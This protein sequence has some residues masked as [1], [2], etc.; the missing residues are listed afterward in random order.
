LCNS[1][2]DKNTAGKVIS[3]FPVS[4]GIKTARYTL[5]I[6]IDKKKP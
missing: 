1:D 5:A 6:D 4:R 3:Y 2:G